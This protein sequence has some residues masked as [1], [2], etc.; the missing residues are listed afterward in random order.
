MSKF[1]VR[2]YQQRAEDEVFRLWGT[3][4]RSVL[5]V[6]FTGG[7]KTVIA[8]NIAKRL[9]PGQ[10]MLFQVHREELAYQSQKSLQE[11]TGRQVALEMSGRKAFQEHP[12]ASIV[13]AMCQSMCKRLEGYRKDHFHVFAQDEAHHL[14][15]STFRAAYDYFEWKH[16][17][18][19]TA[20]PMRSDGVALGKV[21]DRTCLDLMAISGIDDGWLTPIRS[22]VETIADMDLSQV[23]IDVGD[24]NSK[25]LGIQL[26]KQSVVHNIAEKTRAIAAG[27]QTVLFCKSIDQSK[28]VAAVLRQMGVKA[29]HIDGSTGKGKWAFGR[30]RKGEREQKMDRFRDGS[31]QMLINVG[32]I[33]EGVDVPGIEVVGNASP[34]RSQARIIQRIGRGLRPVEPPRGATPE[35]RRAEIANS[36]KPHCTV[37][38]FLGGQMGEHFMRVSGDLLGGEFDDDVRKIAIKLASKFNG[39]FIDWADIYRQAGI[40]AAEKEKA[41]TEA[42]ERRQQLSL[43]QAAEHRWS[44]R[45]KPC[46][47]D[48]FGLNKQDAVE[49]KDDAY[50]RQLADAK[51]YLY[52]S[53]FDEADI[54]R[55]SNVE[56]Y[57]LGREYWKFRRTHTE[58]V[59]SWKQMKCLY[60]RGYKPSDYR[61]RSTSASALIARVQ[62]AGWVRPA[63]D[64]LNQ[65]FL[66]ATGRDNE[67]KAV[68]AGREMDDFF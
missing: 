20:T 15:A 44:F 11:I 67:L 31:L 6:L 3:G 22:R 7:G 17:F 63:E 49:Y 52:D 4:F 51:K 59:A 42:E 12:D 10:R 40:I 38:D 37:I 60:I 65:V 47:F 18:G 43:T 26:T 39:E 64:G 13:V 32:L 41:R 55:L 45:Y 66:E 9:Q 5:I 33:D 14:T 57:F 25:Q 28:A 62:Q 27:R 46:P 35:E 61:Y 68:Q 1:S 48:V 29:E 50:G 56:Q 58:N 8:G 53:G 34:T 30:Y 36:S 19:L 21:F 16:C 24:F 54:A 23:K 2:D